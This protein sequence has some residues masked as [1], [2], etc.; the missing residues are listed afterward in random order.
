MFEHAHYTPYELYIQ[1][2]LCSKC[3]KNT[4]AAVKC[5]CGD[6]LNALQDLQYNTRIFMHI[7]SDLGQSPSLMPDLHHS[8]FRPV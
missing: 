3:Y 8:I 4:N 5:T 1:R 2:V 6:D 7:C